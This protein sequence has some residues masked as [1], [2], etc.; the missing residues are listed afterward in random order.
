MAIIPLSTDG[1]IP[2]G[3]I[4]HIQS[5]AKSV[6]LAYARLNTCRRW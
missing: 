2:Q 6:T 1:A 5:T 3:F 4:A